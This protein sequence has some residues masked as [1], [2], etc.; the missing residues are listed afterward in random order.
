VIWSIDELSLPALQNNLNDA[1]VPGRLPWL[2][3]NIQHAITQQE[4]PADRQWR[5]RYSRAGVVIE[6]HLAHLQHLQ[7]VDNTPD[8]FD[9]GIRSTKSQTKVWANASAVSRRW[10]VVS[11]LDVDD[12]SKA[13]REA[14]SV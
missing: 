1:G 12:F 6:S 7:D 10:G 14:S 8:P 5:L 13:L 3:E 4:R 2:L 11:A 9:P